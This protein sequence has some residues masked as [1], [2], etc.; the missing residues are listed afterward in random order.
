[1]VDGGADPWD[2][3]LDGFLTHLTAERGLA[4]NTLLAYRRDAAR[5][6]VWARRR[7]VRG[8]AAVTGQ[9]LR[10][11]L[12]EGA[13]E[14]APRSRARLISTLRSFFRF[15]CSEGELSRDP[16]TTIQSPRTGRKLPA[17]LSVRQVARLVDAA[18][19]ERDRAVLELLYGCG[20]RVSELCALDVT[21]LDAREG[22]LR[23]RGK[24]D[25]QRLL[26]VGEPALAAVGRYRESDRRRALGGR[27]AAALVLNRRG[28]RIS[29]VAVWNLVK[30]YARTAGLVE[31]V[32]PHTLRHCYATHLLE[33]G[34]DLRAVQELLGHADIAT[35]EI[36]THVDRAFL[37]EAYR[38]AHPR[39]RGAPRRRAGT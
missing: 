10:E 19:D 23:V 37:V 24:G 1:M 18:E 30:R 7:G 9:G 2:L 22:L 15:L 35:T 29:R 13:G 20:L 31:T 32:S 38:A 28:G 8:P 5:L 27:T 12:L 14:L 39:A 4:A 36:Y 26:P 3:A 17:V 6:A 34:A 11:F 16:T 25:K 21:D 33:G